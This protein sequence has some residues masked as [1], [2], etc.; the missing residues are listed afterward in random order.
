[1]RVL[2]VS[3]GA[4]ATGNF[5][6][7][8]RLRKQLVATGH[9]VTTISP[10][11]II[12]GNDKCPRESLNKFVDDNSIDGVLL[13]HAYKSGLVVT[14]DTIGSNYKYGVIFGGTDLNKD[15]SDPSKLSVI[16]QVIKNSSFCVAFTES[17][18][19]IAQMHS[20][21]SRVLVQPQCLDHELLNT[22][23]TCS[24]PVHT[25]I[26]NND[27]SSPLLPVVF[28][29]PASI[30]PVK[31]PCFLVQLFRRKAHKLFRKHDARL[32]IIGPVADE[33][34][35]QEF[36]KQLGIANLQQQ[37][38]NPSL[39]QSWIQDPEGSS[40]QYMQPLP[41]TELHSYFRC[42][43]FHA[44]VNTSHSEGMSSVILEAMACG[45]PVIARAIPGNSAIIQHG[46]TGFLF[47]TD[48]D[49][50]TYALQLLDSRS[51]RHNMIS[52]AVSYVNKHH[53]PSDEQNFYDDLI[54]K[55][56]KLAQIDEVS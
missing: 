13:L 54:Q 33:E 19:N 12:A 28:V 34:Y 35:F 49:F 20:P 30:R 1:M 37:Q 6:T 26:N 47:E 31:D 42:N 23:V 16:K 52:S 55:Y 14:G 43:V 41:I 9:K 10:Q 17:L 53:H 39:L 40:V 25:E 48:D 4:A 22:D 3:P 50:A 44:L 8:C 38:N 46:K 56:F 15:V 27:C 24:T 21:G 5:T 32:L 18:R 36:C 51:L 11:D 29:L 7:T 45:L 2:I